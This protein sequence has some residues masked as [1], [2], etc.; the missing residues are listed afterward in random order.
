M[1]SRL[2]RLAGALVCLLA[3][4]LRADV[5]SS[6][7]VSK[8][9][10]APSREKGGYVEVMNISASETLSLDGVRLEGDV[11][12][13]FPSGARLAP[14]ACL[15]IAE[16]EAVFAALY[17]SAPAPFGVYAGALR[18]S[19]E[20]RLARE[21]RAGEFADPVIDRVAWN[22]ALGWPVP[23]AGQP[24][25][26][27]RPGED[28]ATPANWIALDGNSK[29]R[30]ILVDWN[31]SWRYLAAAA[32]EGWQ[33]PGFD[34]SAWAEGAGPLGRDTSSGAA[35]WEH[36]LATTFS[37]VKNRVAYYFRTTFT[38]DG[39]TPFSELSLQYMVD[40]AARYY[41]NGVEVA[42]SALFAS[43]EAT[44]ETLATAAVE[45]EGLVYGPVTLSLANLSTGV[46]TLAVEVHQ[47]DPGS[48]DL[49]TGTCLS[50]EYAPG[51]APLPGVPF[52]A[53]AFRPRVP[54]LRIVSLEAD[55]ATIR[56]EDAEALDLSSWRLGD[57]ALSGSLGAGE[58]RKV[59]LSPPKGFLLL[60]GPFNGETLVVHAVASP[61]TPPPEI[62]INEAAGQNALVVNPVTGAF[63]DWFELANP[64]NVAVDISGWLVTDTLAASDP[65]AP[66]TRAA[67]SFTIPS[68]VVLQPGEHLRIWT[69]GNVTNEADRTSNPAALQAPFGLNKRVDVIYLF[70][71]LGRLVDSVEWNEELAPTNTFGRWP[72]MTG[73]WRVLPVPTPGL[74]NRPPRFTQALISAQAPVLLDPGEV[75]AFQ[76]T[77][78]APSGILWR[79]L[80]VDASTPI[81]S[82]FALN[83]RTGA[84]TWLGGAT[85]AHRAMLC[86]FSGATCIDAVS[87]V[88]TVRA[89]DA[90]K[91]V[92]KTSAFSSD[93]GEL[94]LVF[95]E[96]LG[97]AAFDLATWP[98]GA[99]D[100]Q[101]VRPIADGTGVA[102][103]FS[104]PLA[105]GRDYALEAA[106]P[107]MAGNVLALALTF[108]APSMIS[109]PL[110]AVRGVREPIG[111]ASRRNPIAVTEI[112]ASP[113]LRADGRD[114]RFIE[115]Y[116]SAPYP[117]RVGGYEL[118][119]ALSYKFPS[120]AQIP[121]KSFVVVAPS[122]EDVAAVYGLSDVRGAIDGGFS[123]TANVELRDE[124][125]AQ[126]AKIEPSGK[127]PWPAGADGSGH[128]LVLARPTYGHADPK[129]WSL[130][131]RVGGSP[132]A[133]D[134]APDEDGAFVLINEYRAHSTEAEG[135]I[136]LFNI[137]SEEFDLTGCQLALAGSSAV[138]TIPSGIVPAHGYALFTE[139]TLGFRLPGTAGDVLL[140]RGEAAGGAVIAAL[141][142]P[143]LELA[144]AFGR[145]PD[146]G[147]LA[148]RLAQATPGAR[149]A[150][151]EIPPVVLNEIMYNPVSGSSDDEYVELLNLTD[152]AIDLDGWTLSGGIDHTFSTT[153]PAHGFKV[154]PAKKSAFKAL[155]PKQSDCLDDGAYS[156]SLGDRGDTIRLRRPLQVWDAVTD[157]P[158]LKNVVLEEVTYC[159]GGMWG[160]WAD[161]GGSSLERVDPRVDARLASAWAD[162]DE[163]D[164]AEWTTI[165]FTGPLEYGRPFELGSTGKGYGEP[166]RVEIGLYGEG[167]CLVDSVNVSMEG[168]G[169]YVLN[170]SFEE[171]NASWTWVGTHQDSRIE[172]CSD[173]VDGARVLHLRACGRLH[174]GGNGVRGLFREQM[175]TNGRATVSMRVK[176]LAGSP[177]ALLRVRGNWIEASG[178]TL[179]TFAL[180]SPGKRNS[181]ALQAPPE[182]TE[183]FHLPAMPRAGESVQ[184]W[185]R[186]CA[187]DG[188]TSVALEWALDDSLS[189][190]RVAMLP[191]EG[192]WYRGIIR[193]SL[194]EGALAAYHVVATAAAEHPRATVFP[195]GRDCL[196]RWD[197]TPVETAFGAYRAWMTKRALASWTAQNHDNNKPHPFT[198][199]YGNGE[200]I[201]Q[202]AGIVYGGSPLHM[203]SYG[204]PFS[205]DIDYIM[206]FPK[207]D[208]L[209]GDDGAVLCTIYESSEVME[210]FNYSL[211]RKLGL[212]SLY[213]RYVRFVAN[214]KVQS[215][216][217]IVEDTEKPGGDMLKHWYP[218]DKSGQLMKINEWYEYDVNTYANFSK[219][220]DFTTR[221][222]PGATLEAF[223]TTDETGAVSYRTARYRWHWQ[224]RSYKNFEPSDYTEFW[225]LVD[226]MN[227]PSPSLAA[228]RQV[229]DLDAFLGVPAVN[230][231][232]G[233]WDTYGYQRGKNMYLY[234]GA[235]GWGLVGW[236]MDIG[237]DADQ[238]GHTVDPQR[239]SAGDMR[240]PAFRSFLRRNDIS[241]W[242]W[243]KVIKL[244]EAAAPGSEERAE[245]EAKNLALR[246]DGISVG[247][248]TN[249]F[250]NIT[251]RYESVAAQRAAADAAAFRLIS[252]QPGETTTL[253]TS[254][255]TLEGV[256]P[257]LVTEIVLDGAPLALSWTTP[258]NWVAQLPLKSSHTALVLVALGEDGSE[259]G[260]ATAEVVTTADIEAEAER[261]VV[262]SEILSR[263]SR[264]GGGYVE[265]RNL[266]KSVSHD[267]GGW[268]LDGDDEAVFPTGTLLS[269]GGCLVVAENPSVFA[270]VFGRMVTPAAFFASALPPAGELRLRRPASG[271][272][273]ADPIVDRVA[274]GGTGWP[275]A[276]VDEPFVLLDPEGENNSPANWT[277]RSVVVREPQPAQSLVGLDH[278]WRYWTG[279][280][281]GA[282]WMER[283]FDD[284]AWPMGMGPLGH[285]SDS[286]NW[287]VPIRTN[288]PMS[289]GR[290][291]YYF[292]TTF[293]N[294]IPRAEA[295]LSLSYFVD[296]G[297]IVYLNGAEVARS[298]LMPSGTVADSTPAVD[299]QGA[300]GV[301]EGPFEIE[302]G[303]LRLGENVLAVEVHQNGGSSSDLSWCALLSVTN[304]VP[305]AG[306]PGEPD[307]FAGIAAVPRVYLNEVGPAQ[308]ELYN[309][310]TT[311]V[312]LA[313]WTLAE[314][315]R[316]LPL[317][318]ELAAGAF[319]SLPFARGEGELM[320]LK[321]GTVVDLIR[322]SNLSAESVLG[323]F[324]DGADELRLL[325]PETPG[326][327][328]RC[329]LPA[330]RVVLNELMSQ[331]GLFEN[332][333]SGD[334]DDWFE[335]ANIGREAVDIGGWIVTDT[336]TSESPP[337]P[338]TK[339]SK[340][341]TF[342]AGVV[343]AP[344]EILRVWTGSSAAPAEAFDREN[345]QAPFGLGKSGD[346]ILLF[347][348]SLS[349]VDSVAYTREIAKTNA[350]GRW[351]HGTGGWTVL[352]IPTPGLPNRPPRFV[353]A[354]VAVP[355]V[356]SLEEG[357]ERSITNALEGVTWALVPAETGR[358][359][360][361]GLRV[362]PLTGVVTFEGGE[363]GQAAAVLCAFQGETCVDAVSLVFS[364]TPAGAFRISAFAVA[365]GLLSL[366]WEA[367]AGAAYVVE[368][369]PTPSGPWREVPNTSVTSPHVTF[370]P[371]SGASSAFFRVKRVR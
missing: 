12:F 155:Y 158:V 272:E 213:R 185:A 130:S 143:H 278:S 256:A 160:R 102:L 38:N 28:R 282:G 52:D 252:P 134:P 181:R 285:D 71:T 80:P 284:S 119:G 312:S 264:V 239:I 48:S 259:L 326:A 309:A 265:V 267:L 73:A 198:F 203:Q 343:L 156:G 172:T 121:A 294:S 230:H 316:A 218:D 157:A 209:L 212:P 50:A 16:D 332:P 138:Y 301:F 268:Y 195:E 369:A 146:G 9:L 106:V 313:G 115:L 170:S 45:P 110:S 176:W 352:P 318:G 128:S 136:E 64:Q 216:R 362:D 214:G 269:P 366:A 33:A 163:S 168:G 331:N 109:P 37:L 193:G 59:V 124:I 182:V 1:K 353:E 234:K 17:P 39:A 125:G 304:V 261:Q 254:V 6:L 147:A 280:F 103:A 141:A 14:L 354:L 243:R 75:S 319:L 74:P 236:D 153:I 171:T 242:W 116:N 67:K 277:N 30:K 335:L 122:P 54:R 306:T 51:I 159:D 324:P 273:L 281:P 10:T 359:I 132:G 112:A 341:L 199:V 245:A 289:S 248:I 257:F 63:D 226:V 191:A 223:K 262:F 263:P 86:A 173:A 145:T 339:A 207:D 43:G 113:P 166:L 167:E 99:L 229:I 225:R 311:G 140:R 276:A 175:P 72:D 186:V 177:D 44:D 139:E 310:G 40:D 233:N 249:R 357:E 232:V 25:V 208:L 330:R 283:E 15:A 211:L 127:W 78:E 258:T 23:A 183:C 148:A 210:Q 224:R 307:D 149:N 296:D 321:D 340:A 58:S 7:V 303:S 32:P 237:L 348:A 308:T 255:C 29:V 31:A 178:S 240:D 342:P 135:F 334:K 297:A 190:N 87:L 111:P 13:V 293:T 118:S 91:P 360:P 358:Q 150:R 337:I 227:A 250:N 89:A 179:T 88:V 338:S 24:L 206:D 81:P 56:N 367:K 144:R 275:A 349:L 314:G 274:W 286:K 333:A 356:C 4:A 291:T 370:A 345:P 68:G 100:V 288:F 266:S 77:C 302:P 184:V 2:G 95:S 126:L 187:P 305:P 162:S 350:Y 133:D 204:K 19:G 21:A 53:A 47:N 105:P 271:G 329:D 151:R 327:A 92:L 8:I 22:A 215:G 364:V 253:A 41:L 3:S 107:D 189:T 220:Y 270:E 164:K 108:R 298:S 120:G 18:E 196:V 129:A 154:A 279:G 97:E 351:P 5:D 62:V 368:T 251:A 83:S 66:N 292:R 246:A 76:F 241:R 235:A 325:E 96:L 323:R 300:E 65:P 371:P 197:E 123:P 222:Q 79:L 27:I 114:L 69:G 200:R 137:G 365:D 320:L 49:V 336:L 238:S 355:A 344:G 131:A 322:C 228:I 55:G 117:Q 346:R 174:T 35:N 169:N 46:N 363:A 98:H 299:A 347:D 94:F 317:S 93:N 244:L 247:N 34:D 328:N 192:G 165:S 188:L 20:V 287:T 90:E 104:E 60:R 57:V 70:N 201:I 85:G 84:L 295:R 202:R 217:G 101:A 180:G 221:L 161:G 194:P 260:R 290:I 61:A 142:I 36:P 82:A 152:E 205:G 231:F 26:L 361:D 11:A 219:S 42:R 315:E